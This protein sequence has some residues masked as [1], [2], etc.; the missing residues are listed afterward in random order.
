MASI[1]EVG[2]NVLGGGVGV[3]FFLAW[4]GVAAINTA[5]PR[6]WIAK[7]RETRVP[8]KV[9]DGG[10]MVERQYSADNSLKAIHFR[11][12]DFRFSIA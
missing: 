11:A 1:G 12:P 10:V 4:A 2:G 6:I 5:S 3:C 8:R 7:G 9:M